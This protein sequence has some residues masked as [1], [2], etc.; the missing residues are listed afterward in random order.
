MLYIHIWYVHE[1]ILPKSFVLVKNRPCHLKGQCHEIFCFWF[2]HESP[3]PK[4]LKITLESI[5]MFSKI[6]GYIR[7]SRCTTGVNDTGGKFATGVNDSGGKVAAGINDTSSR[8]ATSI[9]DTGGNF[10]HQFRLCC[11]H[12]WQIMGTISGCRHLKVNLKAKFYIYVNSST[13]RCPNKII[14]NFLIEDFF[15]LSQRHRLCTL[16]YEYLRE[17]CEKIWNGLNGILRALGETDSWKK[18]KLKISWH[19]P[20]KVRIVFVFMHIF[21]DLLYKNTHIYKYLVI[22]YE[23]RASVQVN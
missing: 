18:Q 15:Y 7:K 22:F 21:I 17:F 14:K 2:F 8:F 19:C 4:P 12:R 16:N 3:S 9:N 10:C 23:D 11:W 13:Q 20:F 6:C 1:L 5:R